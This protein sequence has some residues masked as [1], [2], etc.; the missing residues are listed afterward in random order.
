MVKAVY[1]WDSS[2]IFTCQNPL[3]KSIMVKMHHAYHTFQCFLDPQQR[4]QILFHVHTLS[5]QTSMQKCSNPSFFLTSTTMLHHGDWLGRIT[6]T[7]SISQSEVCTSSKSGGGMHLNHS[8]NDSLLVIQ[9]SCS[10]A[11]V[12]PSSFPSS[13]KMLWKAK[14]KS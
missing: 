8:L 7:S 13:V 3:L 4:I 6:P 11:L 5:L 10:I 1:C 12:Q 14:M 9:I 2:T